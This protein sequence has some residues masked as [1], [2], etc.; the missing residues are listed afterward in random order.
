MEKDGIIRKSE[1]PWSSPVVLVKKK[2][3]KLRFCVD[4]RKL[5]SITKKDTY[6]LPR[7]DE[8]LDNLGKAKWFT[9]L[10]LTSGYWQVQVKEE[11]KEKTAFITKYGLYEFNVMP[12]G[13]CNAPSTFQRLMDVVLSSVLWKYA[14]VYIDDVNIYS[15][16]FEQH[17]EH[18]NE[19]FKLIKKANLQ[20]NPEKCHF[21]TNEMQFLG[22][23]VGIDGIKPNPQKVEKLEKLPSPKNITQLRAFIGLASYYRRFIEGFAKKAA[24][25]HE[26]LKKNV[27]F[28]WTDK[29][30]EIFNWLKQRLITPPILQ[31]P[32]YNISFIL[33]TDASYQ[34]IGAVLAQ[35]K[36]KKEYVIA[37]ASR[38]LSPAEKNYSTVEL[39][40]LAVVWAVKYF[41][42][43]IH[44]TRFTLVTDHKA[45][46]WLL[47]S[48]TINDNKRI[49]R[50]RLTLQ[51]YQY[52][53]KY[54]AGSRNQ[55][56]D[57]FSRLPE[58][59]KDNG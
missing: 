49:T 33:F 10:D 23:I 24:P 29:H 37:Y 48:T 5:N 56:A 3:G 55:N 41:R 27:E 9:S 34:G 53:I 36:D 14:M 8:M 12:F 4:Y 2:N 42:H 22:H 47:N 39:E 54:R 30:E 20:I 15:E 7:I 6:P 51:E 52:D 18:L 40:C 11:D 57:F 16:S 38:T 45:L 32:D 35:I 59:Y 19:V 25:L 21:C 58:F 44:G 13:L 26:L 43:Y 50:W 46:Q 28:I 17:L 31:Y 1:S